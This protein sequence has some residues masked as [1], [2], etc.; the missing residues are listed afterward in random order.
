MAACSRRRGAAG[1]PRCAFTLI[2]LLVVIAIIVLL[3]GILLPALSHARRAA[4]ATKCLSNLHNLALA[5]MLYADANKEL[6]V[7]VGL[8]HGGPGDPTVSWVNTLAPYYDAP[9]V[10][11]SP[12][13]QSV[14]W[15]VE[16]DGGGG[17]LIGGQ[18]RRT[19]YSINN[20]LSR[21][22]NPG[23]HPNE[24]FDRLNRI[25]MPAGTVQFLMM[26][27]EG[28]FA[29]SD[30]PHAEGWD[31][32]PINAPPALVSAELKTHAWGGRAKSWKALA[33]YSYLDGHA[34][35]RTFESVFT[36][37]LKTQFDPTVA[38]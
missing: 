30:H 34:E 38:R 22:F 11:R 32:G 10:V 25:S 29:V 17:Q 24:P 37:H 20:W 6:L 1:G 28:S 5:Q 33:N 14:Y 26:T 19:S 8:G 31:P 36:N 35:G 4:R 15:P 7:D 2:E 9:L 23:V 3:V 21:T 13:D 27:E 18:P 12:G 16:P